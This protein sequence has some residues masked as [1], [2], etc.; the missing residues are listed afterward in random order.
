MFF[1]FKILTVPD[2]T[3][4]Q[5]GKT[6]TS[7]YPHFR[8]HCHSLCISSLRVSACR[9]QLPDSLPFP[10][11]IRGIAV[12]LLPTLSLHSPTCRGER[13]LQTSWG[14]ANTEKQS[15]CRFSSQH[16]LAPHTLPG[17]GLTVWSLW[18]KG[19]GLPAPP[20]SLQG[21]FCPGK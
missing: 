10:L 19:R 16:L 13:G 14:Q 12:V 3:T 18:R 21:G 20:W 11:W 6:I 8:K 15:R 4:G 7:L 1:V 17:D 9:E 2:L 5:T